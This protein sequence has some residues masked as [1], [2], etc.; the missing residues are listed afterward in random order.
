MPALP[1]QLQ[2]ASK[3]GTPHP[4]PQGRVPARR[5]RVDTFIPAALSAESE[6]HDVASPSGS[7]CVIG[8]AAATEDADLDFRPDDA[9]ICQERLTG[10]PRL[11]S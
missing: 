11:L 4:G 9:A 5:L 8:K 7:S 10:R 2:A 1:P 3:A 6:T